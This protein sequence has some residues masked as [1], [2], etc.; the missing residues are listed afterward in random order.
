MAV[1]APILG[2]IAYDEVAV[3]A[4]IQV[5]DE[6]LKIVDAVLKNSKYLVGDH[7]TIADIALSLPFLWLFRTAYAEGKRKSICSH[8]EKWI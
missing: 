1:I 8:V 7:I 4:A 5:L 6:K 3:K 2:F